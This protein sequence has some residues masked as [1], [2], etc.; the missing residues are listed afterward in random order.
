MLR[1]GSAP[2]PKEPRCVSGFKSTLPLHSPSTLT[3]YTHP[4]TLTVS[5][6][7]QCNRL[8][9]MH[10]LYAFT[11]CIKILSAQKRGSPGAR[12]R[13]KPAT[14]PITT[15]NIIRSGRLKTRPRRSK[16]PLRRSKTFHIKPYSGYFFLK[17]F[18]FK[19][20]G[21]PPGRRRAAS[22]APRVT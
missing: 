5:I 3:L 14:A 6:Y 2:G 8:G 18:F 17:A 12:R 22:L 21:Q 1:G 19:D 15:H 13:R 4:Y 20:I 11:L 10:L 9:V 7:I 16:T